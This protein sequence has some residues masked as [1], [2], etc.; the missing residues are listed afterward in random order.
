MDGFRIRRDGD[1]IVVPDVAALLDLARAGRLGGADEIRTA[2]G[3]VRADQLP[4]LKGHLGGDPWSAWADLDTVDAPGLYRRMVEGGE[5]E[6]LPDEALAPVDRRV[7]VVHGP[8]PSIPEVAITPLEDPAP[9]APAAPVVRPVPRP[10]TPLPARPARPPDPDVGPGEVLDFPRP[11]PLP[12]FPSRPRRPAGTTVAV[13]ASRL[14]FVLVLGGLALA[15]GLSW[16]RVQGRGGDAGAGPTAAVGSA[17]PETSPAKAM[18]ALE[19]EL[20]ANLSPTPRVV[21]TQDDLQDAVMV[22]LVQFG[23]DVQS[24]D[25]RVTHWVGRKRDE[26]K[27]AEVRVTFRKSD[28]VGRDIGAIALVV[29]R[30]KRLY[31][32]DLPVFEVV[33]AGSGGRTVLDPDKAELFYQARLPLG[34]F[35]AEITGS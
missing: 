35:L 10:P 34:R 7:V 5:P 21:R 32:L 8:P 17:T 27:T 25:V 28:D 9:P 33:E 15:M 13:R 12:D 26:P 31:R 4:E 29:G 11:P 1:E 14:V 18:L 30:Y 6:E 23:V 3:W 24:V 16:M 19:Q 22:E 20:R 2:R